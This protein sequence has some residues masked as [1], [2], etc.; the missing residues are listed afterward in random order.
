MDTR[1]S[2][3]SNVNH[4]DIKRLWSSVRS[5]SSSAPK[6][7]LVTSTPFSADDLAGYFTDVATDTAYDPSYI[8]DTIN[9]L[10]HKIAS[11]SHHHTSPPPAVYEYEVFKCLSRVKKTSP[12]PD[13]I[14]YWLFKHCALELTPIITHINLSLNKGKPPQ[15]W[16]KAIITPVPKV[17]NLKNSQTSALF[18][19]RLSYLELLNA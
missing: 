8:T 17:P 13:K 16:K 9:L 6:K 14:P 2:Q 1:A 3:L 15:L 18:P 19:S 11:A 10:S 7:S 5:T 4:K 12:G